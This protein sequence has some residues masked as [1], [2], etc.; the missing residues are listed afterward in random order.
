MMLLSCE[1]ELSLLRIKA[2]V[3]VVLQEDEAE[4]QADRGSGS[5]YLSRRKHLQESG[6]L[7]I[8]CSDGL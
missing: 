4:R 5:I 7:S 1:S 2:R 3:G 8:V 6:T